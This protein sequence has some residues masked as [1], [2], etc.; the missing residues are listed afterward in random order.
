MNRS[1]AATEQSDPVR[2]LD[3]VRTAPV[4]AGIASDSIRQSSDRIVRSMNDVKREAV[5]GYFGSVKAAAIA[6]GVDASQM[7][8]EFKA[9]NFE[10]VE[11]LEDKGPMAAIAAA[12]QAEYGDTT[13]PEARARRILRAVTV[14]LQ[15]LENYLES[16]AARRQEIA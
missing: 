8:R 6:L 14:G 1:F 13:S 7:Q 4:K 16:V 3:N 2:S 15:E 10:R 12:M 5:I 9:G 11:R